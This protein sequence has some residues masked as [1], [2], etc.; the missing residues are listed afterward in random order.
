MRDGNTQKCSGSPRC[1]KSFVTQIPPRCRVKRVVVRHHWFPTFKVSH[2]IFVLE[3][4]AYDFKKK[5]FWG[6]DP[7][8]HQEGRVHL[9]QIQHDKAPE[10]VIRSPERIRGSG[11][12]VR[13]RFIY[14]RALDSV[15]RWVLLDGRS[16]KIRYNQSKGPGVGITAKPIGAYKT[17]PSGRFAQG[18]ATAKPIGAHPILKDVPSP[19]TKFGP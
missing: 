4:S 9:R 2:F 13:L 12:L 5:W 14:A 1:L 19:C 3:P 7:R 16:D 15:C 8:Y 17:I 18:A 6:V 10:R 11:R